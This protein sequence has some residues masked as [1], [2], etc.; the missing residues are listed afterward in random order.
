V[1]DVQPEVRRVV[2]VVP[3]HNEELLLD[4]CLSALGHACEGVG[5]E[6]HVIVVL[7]SCTDSSL[8]IAQ[9]WS[10]KIDATVVTVDRR[11][12]GAARAA[13]FLAAFRDA[14]ISSYS[15]VWFATTDAD[16]EVGGNWLSTQLAHARRGARVVAGTV[17]PDSDTVSPALA[18]AYNSGY[19]HRPGHRHVHG[20]NL[21]FRADAYW[22]VGGFGALATAEDVDLVSRLEHAG[23]DVLYASDGPVRTSSRRVGRAPDG[24]AGHLL[25]LELAI[26]L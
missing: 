24:F 22:S 7:D 26:A 18:L 2:V 21:G 23:I 20:T 15:D 19:R 8:D 16:S 4:A 10:D 5:V 17:T 14:G 12:V 1:I 6:T 9:T 25:D 3:V 11:N 13:G